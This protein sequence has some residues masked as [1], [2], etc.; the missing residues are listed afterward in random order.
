MEREKVDGKP[1]A[2]KLADTCYLIYLD[3]ILIIFSN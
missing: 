3:T 1:T 2:F